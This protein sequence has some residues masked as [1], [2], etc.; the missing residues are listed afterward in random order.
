MLRGIKQKHFW[1]V[2]LVLVMVFEFHIINRGEQIPCSNKEFIMQNII[3][4]S[5]FKNVNKEKLVEEIKHISFL[6]KQHKLNIRRPH[7]T[8]AAGGKNI[9]ASKEIEGK[10]FWVD[11]SQATL[12]RLKKDATLLCSI[13]A[14]MRGKVH[15]QLTKK[16]A[17]ERQL[18]FINSFASYQAWESK[19]KYLD[20][21]A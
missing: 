13:R 18:E 19:I 20:Q 3:T 1:H 6:I 15:R 8:G 12:M 4:D 2:V 5:Q 10:K 11:G 14:A 17:Q 16:V 7:F 9:M 21:A